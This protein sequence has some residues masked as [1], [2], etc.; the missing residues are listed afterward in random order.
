MAVEPHG[1]FLPSVQS[2]ASSYSWEQGNSAL[3]GTFFPANTSLI[4]TL[5][6]L[7]VYYHGASLVDKN[8]YVN[9]GIDN[10]GNS[11]DQCF[12]V[13]LGSGNYSSVANRH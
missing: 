6:S 1:S 10:T 13:L 2:S 3:P 7:A 12:T 5:A 8:M 9:G 4:L 11:V